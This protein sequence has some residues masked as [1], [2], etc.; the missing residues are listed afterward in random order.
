MKT[1]LIPSFPVMLVIITSLLLPGCKK[2]DYYPDHHPHCRIRQLKGDL[3]FSNDSA[4]FV[5]NAK[6]DPVSV[7]KTIPGTGSPNY[8]FRY[9]AH[10][11]LT[12]FIGV[13]DGGVR[14][15]FR[16]RYGYDSRNRIVQDTTYTFGALTDPPPQGMLE[17]ITTYTYDSKNRIVRAEALYPPNGSTY[18]IRY[19]YNQQGN[20]EKIDDGSATV[21]TYDKKVNMHRTHPIWQ[22]ID[23]D[24]SVNNPFQAVAYNTRGLP[25]KIESDPTKYDKHFIGIPYRQLEISYNCY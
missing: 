25:V 1:A 21:L 17:R 10:R 20:L 23:R 24:F 14:F 19:Y 9:D 11:R 8:L 6:G 18:V 16:H 5:Y 12:D 13:Y 3:G 7:T 2:D 22:F 15:E 4:V